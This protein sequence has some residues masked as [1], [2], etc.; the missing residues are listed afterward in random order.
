ML[1]PY[2][3]NEQFVQENSKFDSTKLKL[4][5]DDYL[6][7]IV[8][9]LINSNQSTSIRITLNSLTVQSNT[10][11]QAN[12]EPVKVVDNS[13]ISQ[14]S[15]NYL[16]NDSGIGQKIVNSK[17]EVEK[18][19]LFNCEDLSLKNTDKKVYLSISSCSANVSLN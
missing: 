13:D 5:S 6:S 7:T 16:T 4:S 12:V 8:A 10:S 11:P 1:W 14:Q 3:L 19:E 17:P 9:N 2:Y 18:T 15:D